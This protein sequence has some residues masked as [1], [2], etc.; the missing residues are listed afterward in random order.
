MPSEKLNGLT[1]FL[2]TPT[3]TIKIA[4]SSS[5]FEFKVHTNANWIHA[6]GL[7]QKAI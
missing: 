7:F 2:G 6:G 1:T 5:K 3:T 4:R